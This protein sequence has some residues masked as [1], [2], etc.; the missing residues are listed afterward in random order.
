MYKISVYDHFSS[1]H[2]LK[3]YKGKCE[4]LHGH[5]WKVEIE[6][7]G[8]KLDRVGLLI[9]FNEV[10]SILKKIVD[11]L[12]HKML[13]EIEAFSEQNPSSEVIA[14]YI[15][16]RFKKELPRGISIINV[17]IWESERSKA[18]YSEP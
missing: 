12:D 14:K 3:G 2:Q 6:V 11:E 8:K 1:A 9:D 4:A 18:S 7:G 16:L 13:N 15:F 10:K 17:S 5:N